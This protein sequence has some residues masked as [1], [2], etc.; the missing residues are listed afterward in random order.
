MVNL[1][2]KTVGSST[3]F[4]V[5]RDIFNERHP[6]LLGEVKL[7]EDGNWYFRRPGTREWIGTFHTKTSAQRYLAGFVM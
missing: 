3:H 1:V 7:E 4:K 6:Q 5:Y 2:P